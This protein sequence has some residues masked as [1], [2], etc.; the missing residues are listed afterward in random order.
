MTPTPTPG[1]IALTAAA[2][3]RIVRDTTTLPVHGWRLV[4]EQEKK[5]G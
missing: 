2:A 4:T 3:R 1:A 5:D